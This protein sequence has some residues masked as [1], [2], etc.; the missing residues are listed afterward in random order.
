[1]VDLHFDHRRDHVRQELNIW[2]TFVS[3]GHYLIVEDTNLNGNPVLPD[4]GP[5]P[6]EAVNEFL[7]GN[8]TLRVDEKRHQKYP[9]IVQSEGLPLQKPVLRAASQ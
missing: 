7:A 8:S 1:M 3:P 6:M 4:Y 5:G 2:S 9:C